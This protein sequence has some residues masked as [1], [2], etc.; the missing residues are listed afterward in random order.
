VQDETTDA[1]AFLAK[2]D[3]DIMYFHQAMKAPNRD[4]S[5]KAIMKEMNDHIVSKNWELVPRQDVPEG[6]KVLASI[7]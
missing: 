7:C 3:E 4:K 2:I 5:V 1:I 6:M